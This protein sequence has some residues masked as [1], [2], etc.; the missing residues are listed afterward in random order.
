M[1]KSLINAERR[2]QLFEKINTRHPNRNIKININNSNNSNN[3][4]KSEI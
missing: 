3:N 1:K 2:I 4:V